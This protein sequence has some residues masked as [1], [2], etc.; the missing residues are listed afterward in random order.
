LHR[1]VMES[2]LLAAWNEGRWVDRADEMLER[3]RR[4][5]WHRGRVHQLDE[6]Q[7][8]PPLAE[9]RPFFDDEG[10]RS[11]RTGEHV[12][13]LQPSYD[14][15]RNLP[16]AEITVWRLAGDTQTISWRLVDPPHSR[17]PLLVQ[18]DRSEEAG[19]HGDF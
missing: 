14:G 5:R 18:Y 17:G 13:W 3:L 16:Q 10:N 19:V 6:G 2:T 15:T 9:L 11:P 4:T 7:S 8:L 1:D 12:V